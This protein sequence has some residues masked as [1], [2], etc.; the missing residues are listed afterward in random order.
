M[1]RGRSSAATIDDRGDDKQGFDLTPEE[2]AELVRAVEEADRDEEQGLLIPWDDL[3]AQ[4][5]RA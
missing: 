3:L 1:S 5:R 2:E 4:L